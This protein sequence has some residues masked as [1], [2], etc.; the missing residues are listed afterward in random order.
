MKKLIAALTGVA[1]VSA[2]A[3]SSPAAAG[4]KGEPAESGVVSR[5]DPAIGGHVVGPVTTD[6]NG[7]DLPLLAVFGW[8][9]EI[10]FCTGGDPVENGV[11]QVVETPSGNFTDV[12][13]NGD[14][15]VLVFDVTD[16]DS[17]AQFI[18][19]CATGQLEPL[20]TGTAKQRPIIN[21]NDTGLTIKIKSQ[22]VVTDSLD[23]EWKLQAFLKENI[24]FGPPFQSDVQSEWIKLNL[25]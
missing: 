12:V 14:I 21:G 19:L 11:V 4:K 5:I 16:I 2:M 7:D 13:H 22:G 15:P 9:D 8:D 10:S 23:R 25:L 6:V 1:L 18:S 17:E 24:V 3:V 20:A